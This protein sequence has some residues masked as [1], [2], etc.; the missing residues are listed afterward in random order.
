MDIRERRRVRHEGRHK[1]EQCQKRLQGDA[2]MEQRLG[3]FGKDRHGLRQQ[4][5]RRLP[6]ASLKAQ[7]TQ[8]MQCLRL[9]GDRFE[10]VSVKC[11][12]LLPLARIVVLNRAIERC[13]NS[14]VC[15]CR[16]FA[17][18][19]A[20]SGHARTASVRAQR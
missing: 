13:S 15:I 17:P 7:Q 1:H 6:L 18:V 9:V 16:S 14:T 5:G 2:E 11:F 4:L 10:D 20:R 8:K 12:R 3:V 19:A